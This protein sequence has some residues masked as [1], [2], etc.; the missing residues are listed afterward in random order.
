MTDKPR[1]TATFPHRLL[2]V[3]GLLTCLL[4]STA[5]A[6]GT[7][8][9]FGD[10]S[11]APDFSLP[12]LKGTTRTLADF[13][14]KVVIVNF[15]ASW[16]PPCIQEMPGLKR[17]QE[18]RADQPFVILAVNVG[19]KKYRVWKFARLIDFT[20]SVLLDTRSKVFEDW[21]ASVLPTSF[22]LD[23]AGR[24]RYRVQGDLEWDSEPVLA[25]IDELLAES[26]NSD[27]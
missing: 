9:P 7:L 19:E 20:L 1:Q 13:R 17:L 3:M 18:K 22:M 25:L 27:E 15:W 14:G 12:D 10:D 5:S 8:Q 6:S 2:I 23:S 11:P 16:C 26:D 4:A 24:I 21:G